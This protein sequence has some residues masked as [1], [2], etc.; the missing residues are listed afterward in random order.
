MRT[1]RSFP[2]IITTKMELSFDLVNGLWANF[3]HYLLSWNA[4]RPPWL[5][6]LGHDVQQRWPQRAGRPNNACLLDPEVL[7]LGCGQLGWVQLPIFSMNQRPC[8][9]DV[10]LQPM[11][12]ETDHFLELIQHPLYWSFFFGLPLNW[13][14][15]KVNWTCSSTRP[16][17]QAHLL[18]KNGGEGRCR[19]S[20]R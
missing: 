1:W 17:A 10:V 19:V 3:L 15:T 7:S 13:A 6:R 20:G 5:V 4:T 9:H 12:S 11:L 18:E 2:L 16:S 8:P 14:W